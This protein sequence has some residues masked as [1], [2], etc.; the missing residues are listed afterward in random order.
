MRDM[1]HS[2]SYEPEAAI[3]QSE[4]RYLFANAAQDWP[5]N[6]RNPFLEM[7]GKADRRFQITPPIGFLH[8]VCGKPSESWNLPI[9]HKID[10]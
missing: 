5:T 2:A 6:V 9:I 8:Q 4:L 7:A 1:R 10:I 3:F